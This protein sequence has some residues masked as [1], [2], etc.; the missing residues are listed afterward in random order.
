MTTAS[1]TMIIFRYSP[2]F[3]GTKVRKSISLAQSPLED[4]ATKGI[5]Q[6]RRFRDLQKTVRV[7]K[8]LTVCV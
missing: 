1:G 5:C 8:T 6:V 2:N 4:T 3:A 7:L